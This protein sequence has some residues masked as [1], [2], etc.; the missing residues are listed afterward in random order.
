MS[1]RPGAFAPRLVAD[2]YEPLD[3]L[4]SG[5]AGTVWRAR[6]RSSDT[7]VA[8]KILDRDALESPQAELRFEREARLMQRLASPN[9]VEVLDYGEESGHAFTVL[10]L[11]E[12]ET[13]RDRLRRE[14]RLPVVEAVAIA[15]QVGR[16]LSAA[17]ARGIVHRDLKPANVLITLDGR[18]KLADFGIAQ[19]VGEPGVTTDGHVLGSGE[20]MSP[21]QAQGH[22]LDGRSDL[23]SLGILLFEM[24]AGRVPFTGIGFAD[25]AAKHVRTPP[26]SLARFSMDATTS[27]CDLVAS[28]LEK[29]PDARPASTDEVVA[30][31]RSIGAE[32][33]REGTELM[34]AVLPSPEDVLGAQEPAAETVDDELPPAGTTVLPPAVLTAPPAADAVWQD[35]DTDSDWGDEDDTPATGYRPTVAPRGDAGIA[36][37]AA[38]LALGVAILAIVALYVLTRGTSSTPRTTSAAT[39]APTTSSAVVTTAASASTAPQSS[40]STTAGSANPATLT[41]VRVVAAQ[42][43]DPNGDGTERQDLAKL[44]FDGNPATAWTTENYRDQPDLTTFKSGVGLDVDF[45]SAV[46]LAG[47]KVTLTRPGI[48]AAIYVSNETD[49][50]TGLDSWTPATSQKVLTAQ[51]T[52]ITFRKVRRSRHLLIWI[53]KL[54]PDPKGGYI[55]SVGELQPLEAPAK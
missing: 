37:Y 6:D 39:T 5:G 29:T 21:E 13:L 45:A 26:P 34:D 1:G 20:Y 47:V 30:S 23:Y 19:T 24:I 49:S 25:I 16:G 42:S 36:R 48:T 10:E 51:T 11:V 3:L 53:T 12:G 18:V 41:P 33:G 54:A 2:R 14:G 31:L 52:T 38:I 4:G 27:L 46:R 55:A 17:H 40:T 35:A 32:V 43:F 7:L 22:H 50:P 8:L 28:L 9:I 44:A 15:E